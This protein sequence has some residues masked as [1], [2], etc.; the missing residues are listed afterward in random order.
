VS[1]ETIARGRYRIERV[2]GDGAMATVVLARDEE[3]GR[4]VAVKLLDERLADNREFRA[5]FTR[6]G[7]LAAALSHPNVVTVYDAGEADGRPYIV[8][9]YVDGQTLAERVRAEGALDPEE[10]RAIAAQV[11]AGLEHAHG[12]GLVHRD[13]KPGNLIQRTD[14]TTK[15]ADF[16]IARGS[17]GTE[18]TETG[19]IV[20]TAAYLAP[21]QAEGGEVTPRTDLYALGAVLHELLTGRPPWQVRSLADLGRRRTE[22]VPPL[23]PHVPADLRDAVTRALAPDPADRPASAAELSE[24][25]GEGDEAATMVLPRA[26][27][28]RM[29][30]KRPHR[31]PPST[32]VA[33][34]I[35]ALLLALAVLGLVTLVGDGD[36]GAAD[37]GQPPQQQP[38]QPIPDGATPAE[39]ARNL[40]D[41]LRE[42]AR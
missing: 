40:A 10:V 2:L 23:P 39:D 38:V 36:G 27:T 31:Q 14:G 12:Q 1:T 37:R 28:P 21:E 9:E 5:R 26:R 19:A 35:V 34:G 41:W 4:R 22:P 6:E 3:L 20:G 13:L 11:A 30:V 16:G 32:W 33:L 24:L 17:H 15:I 7:R 8:M 18:L 25:L 42:N 29:G